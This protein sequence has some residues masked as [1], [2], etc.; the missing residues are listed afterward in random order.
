ME[1]GINGFLFAQDTKRVKVL[2]SALSLSPLGL[3]SV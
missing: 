3:G 1:L 2:I